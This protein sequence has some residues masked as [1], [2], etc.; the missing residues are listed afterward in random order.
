M[1]GHRWP[2]KWANHHGCMGFLM[3]K[4]RIVATA[5]VAVVAPYFR[6]R[7]HCRKSGRLNFLSCYT[8]PSPGCLVS[9]L[10]VDVSFF[11]AI[12]SRGRDRVEI[13]R[14]L[15]GRIPSIGQIRIKIIFPKM[16]SIKLC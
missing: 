9:F 15:R 7:D 14:V 5:G 2:A 6:S 16:V 8:K 12:S 1:C 10:A 11:P 3:R 4:C 13:P